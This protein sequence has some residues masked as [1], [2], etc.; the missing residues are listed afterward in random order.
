[1]LLA[2]LSL[3]AMRYGHSH[4]AEVTPR[5]E[6]S[7]TCMVM[8]FL[9]SLANPIKIVQLFCEGGIPCIFISAQKV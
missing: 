8:C 5:F 2:R 1:M 6:P 7:S 9:V 4:K 3:L